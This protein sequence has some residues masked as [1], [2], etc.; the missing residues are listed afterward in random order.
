ML[1]ARVHDQREG[2]SDEAERQERPEG[3]VASEP[4]TQ[5]WEALSRAMQTGNTSGQ[6]ESQAEATGEGGCER[7]HVAH[8]ALRHA[9]GKDTPL[10][11]VGH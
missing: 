7:G 2:A 4:E 3:D 1:A 11:R 5:T 10:G 8:E 6:A 9:L